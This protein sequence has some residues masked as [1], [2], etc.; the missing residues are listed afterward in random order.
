M[1]TL[2]PRQAV[3]DNYTDLNS[4]DSVK[5]MGR[6]GDEQ[7]LREV[8]RQFEAMF[9]QQLLKTMRATED[10]FADGNYTQSSEMKFH[11][12]LLDQQMSLSMTQGKGMGLAEA[13]FEQMRTQYGKLLP[14]GAA[15]T[16]A[17]PAVEKRSMT[18]I[19]ASPLDAVQPANEMQRSS[20]IANNPESKIRQF[21]EGVFDA[22]NAAAKSLGVAVDG[23][24]AQAALE[25]G[26]GEHI[27]TDSQG[28]VSNNL[29]NIKADA[30]WAG[31]TVTK[32]VLE[33]SDGR[34]VQMLSD[35]RKY[36]SLGEAFEDFTQFLQSS[37]RYE[38]ALNSESVKEYASA[39]QAGGYATDPKYAHKIVQIAESPLLKKILAQKLL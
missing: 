3:L 36:A 18:S 28:D 26:W 2:P 8:A 21:V 23:V 32:E 24:I 35:F 16:A 10:V 22:A 29:F 37:S 15:G 12:D 25:T 34:P 30:R 14:Q 9:V 7:S 4:L 33:Y 1:E 5:K 27:L 31:P 6:E 11:R 20:G 13:L 38:S 19:G 17:E 39:L